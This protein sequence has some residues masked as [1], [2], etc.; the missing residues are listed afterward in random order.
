MIPLIAN[1][2]LPRE[3]I[4]SITRDPEGGGAAAFHH[5]CRGR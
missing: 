5:S 2:K 1:K 3:V 4:K